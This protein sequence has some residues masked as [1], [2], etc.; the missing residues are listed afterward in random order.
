MNEL[1]EIERTR[2]DKVKADVEKQLTILIEDYRIA[3]EGFSVAPLSYYERSEIDNGSWIIFDAVLQD[4]EDRLHLAI[5]GPS[6]SDL[7]ELAMLVRK[8]EDLKELIQ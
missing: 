1:R 5:F 7:I 4:F 2:I 3:V 6:S 8:I